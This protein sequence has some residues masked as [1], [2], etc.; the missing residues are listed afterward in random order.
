[1]SLVWAV[2]ES[3]RPGRE[4]GIEEVGADLMKAYYQSLRDEGFPEENI[5]LAERMVKERCEGA[6][7][8]LMPLDEA[9]FQH[10]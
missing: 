5:R 4:W 1:M 10:P 6:E 7:W 2:R 3:P 9:T 8:G